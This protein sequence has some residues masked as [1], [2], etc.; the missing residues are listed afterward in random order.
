MAKEKSPVVVADTNE[1]DELLKPTNSGAGGDNEIDAALASM[2][3]GAAPDF[4]AEIDLGSL[5]LSGCLDLDYRLLI[6]GAKYSAYIGQ[7]KGNRRNGS[8]C[9]DMVFIVDHEG[10]LDAEGLPA[11]GVTI[12]DYPGVDPKQPQRHFRIKG[13]AAA[14]GLA[15]RNAKGEVIGVHPA[16]KAPAFI[17]RRVLLTIRNEEYPTGSGRMQSKAVRID[18]DPSFPNEPFVP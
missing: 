8:L 15:V 2:G 1:L 11:N 14:C 7:S 16:A 6:D 3:G 17:G 4:D 13:I 5:D 18:V 12:N 10:A 9:I